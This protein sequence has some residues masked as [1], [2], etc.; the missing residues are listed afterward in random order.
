M[1]GA[2]ESGNLIIYVAE[3][4]QELGQN[5]YKQTAE[6]EQYPLRVERLR[7]KLEQ[8]ERESRNRGSSSHASL[9]QLL[10]VARLCL[11]EEHKKINRRKGACGSKCWRQVGRTVF[12]AQVGQRIQAAIEAFDN[13]QRMLESQDLTNESFD[14][15]LRSSPFPETITADTRYVPLKESEAKLY[16]ALDR[17]DGPLVVL[18]H[19]GAGKG[20]STVA[21]N[22]VFHYSDRKTRFEHVFLL[23]CGPDARVEETQC[24]LICLLGS[25]PFARRD[26]GDRARSISIRK[27]VKALLAERR[28]L[29]V[30][31]D[32]SDEELLRKVV[33]LCG[34]GVKCL[35]TSRLGS[36]CR[37]LDSTKYTSIEIQ[38]LDQEGAR[39]IL[40]SHSGLP[41][42]QIPAHLQVCCLSQTLFFLISFGHHASLVK[43]GILISVGSLK[44]SLSTRF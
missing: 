38:E 31:D 6:W 15:I 18:L 11:E 41:S 39:K 43:R 4:I 29:I 34:S 44:Y 25:Q 9:A 26:D 36:L 42:H 16:D 37:S 7:V 22:T 2:S 27:Q 23:N 20:K 17:E 40:A 21:R 33:E 8:W 1:T 3:K 14:R 32:V 28:I 10:D 5:Y 19:G 13:I 30:L 24:E 35:I 12:P